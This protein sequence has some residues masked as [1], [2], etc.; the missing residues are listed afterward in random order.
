MAPL[1]RA[2]LWVFTGH[3]GSQVINVILVVVLARLLTPVAFG[4]VATAQ[5]IFSIAD[6]VARLGVGTAII[7]A[8]SITP[9]IARSIQSIMVFSAILVGTIVMS[10]SQFIANVFN[11]QELVN[12]LP[13]MTVTFFLSSASNVSVSLISREMD[14]RFLSIV[15]LLTYTIGYGLVTTALALLGFSHWSLIIGLFAKALVGSCLVLWRY[16]VLPT[17]RPHICEVRPI[18]KFGFS[19]FLSQILATLGQ[20]ADNFVIA[21]TLGATALGH[22]TRAF[23]LMEM[24]NG[25]LGSV[26]SE[27]LLSG[28][29]KR[30][31]EGTVAESHGEAFLE[32]QAG[33]A[34]LIL[35]IA[36]LTFLLCA[37]LV[38]IVL[39]DQWNETADVLRVLAIGMF[40]RLSYKISST[41]LVVEGLTT[42]MIYT[43]AIYA[44]L[45]LFGSIAGS[46]WGLVGISVGVSLALATHYVVLTSVVCARLD[47]RWREVIAAGAPFLIASACAG[48]AGL[49]ALNLM[50][51][52]G[53]KGNLALLLAG[54]VA[55]GASYT[56]MI[57]MMRR[58]HY[59]DR[60]LRRLSAA[61]SAVLHALSTRTG[62]NTRS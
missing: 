10:F 38:S 46:S 24:A 5:I 41:F 60:V 16:P 32:S 49:L 56:F 36:A 33:A 30:R 7:Q 8:K 35:P 54:S 18:L 2:G 39:G 28:V 48:A 25:L 20:R 53:V 3:I 4:I 11:S 43:Y 45:V 34:F 55:V 13:C 57:M 6:V 61:R 15:E 37:P 47:I 42:K 9:Q 26:F 23:S 21:S 29:A 1:L 22:Y 17:I 58:N 12:I 52:G 62:S 14:F 19:I 31:R 44:V 27:T 59:V 50:S 40:F 51:V